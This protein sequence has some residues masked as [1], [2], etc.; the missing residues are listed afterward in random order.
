MP[1]AS[2]SRWLTTALLTGLSACGGSSDNSTPGPDAELSASVGAVAGDEADAALNALSL[3]T[4]LTPIGATVAA[5]CATPSSTTDSDGD[6]I[7]DDA[8]WILT[9]PPCRFTGYRGGTLDLVGQLRIQDPSPDAA[10]FGYAATLTA[11]R[12]TFT[13]GGDNP[14]SFSVTRNG[15]RSL[16]GTVAGLLLTADLQ[17]IRTFTGLSDAAVDEGW[18]VKFTADS[19]LQINEPLPSGTLDVAGTFG[20]TRGAQSLDLTVTTPTPIHYNAGCTSNTRRFDAGELH[21][22]GTFDGTPG[23]VRVRWT[24][25]GAEPEVTFVAD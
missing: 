6:G 15:T 13:T 3:P 21:A 1:H 2:R 24:A 22:A 8:T 14:T 18:T 12:A 11:L 4:L 16:S 23:Y 25:C 9:A 7:P 10:G 19:P 17:V 20:W 5:P